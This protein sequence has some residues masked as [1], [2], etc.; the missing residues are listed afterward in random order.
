MAE[1]PNN[2]SKKNQSEDALSSHNPPDLSHGW[3]GEKCEPTKKYRVP[4]PPKQAA[5]I[6]KQQ[7][8]ESSPD[9]LNQTEINEEQPKEWLGVIKSSVSNL[10]QTVKTRIRA[11]KENRLTPEQFTQSL[12]C[13][14]RFAIGSAFFI[15]VAISA[16]AGFAFI[17]Y[18]GIKNSEDFPDV[19][20]LYEKAAQFETTYILDK[21]GNILYEIVD[22]FA[23]RR[24]YVPLEHM[25]PELIAATIATEDQEF[26]NHPGFDPFAIARALIQ[27]YVAHET[28]SG[29]STITQQLSR[30]ILL[31]P[32]ERYEISYT[33]KAKEIVVAAELTRT[34]SKEEIL[35]IYLNQINFGNQSYGIEA[36]ARTYFDTTAANLSLGQ[37]T[38]LAG[39]PQAPALWDV[40]QNPVGALNRQ[41]QVITLTQEMSTENQCI[42]VSSKHD[43]VCVNPTDA[44]AA[45]VEINNYHFVSSGYK[46]TYPHWVNFIRGWLFDRYEESTIYR[47]GFT[48]YTTL[49]PV[50]QERA[51]SI[52]AKQLQKLEGNNASNAALIAIE[53]TTGQVR[54]MVGSADFYNEA[55]SGQVNMSLAPRQPGSSIKPLVYLA[56]FE[57]G[58]TPSTLLWDI[59]LEFPPSG[60]PDD[61]A[62]PYKPTNYDKRYH[63][64]ITVRSALGNSFN[65]P[66]VSTLNYVGIYDNSNTI[67]E[68]GFLKLA[69]RMGITSFVRDDYGLALAL[70]GGEVSL[71]EMTTAFAILGNNGFNVTPSPI[72][73]II[74]HTGQ[75]VYE[76]PG[77]DFK[78]IAR[79]EH[80][81]LISDI[82]SDNNARTP[83][84]GSNSVLNL[85]F[86]AAAKTGTTNDYR[87]NWTI[88]YTPDLAVGVWVGNADYTPMVD[89]TGLS[90]AAPIWSEF[91]QFAVPEI[92]NNAPTS[93]MPPPGIVEELICSLSG[94]EPSS[95]CPSQIKEYFAYDQLPLSK[96]NDFWAEVMVDP[97][98]GF[99]A[100]NECSTKA[101]E[102]FV[103]NIKDADALSW[104]RGTDQGKQWLKSIG[105]EEPYYFL[106]EKTCSTDDPQVTL[107]IAYPRDGETI[108]QSDL[109]IYAIINATNNFDRYVLSYGLGENPDKMEELISETKTY[110]QTS[111]VYRWN[112][113][114]IP[115]GIVTLKLTLYSNNGSKVQETIHINNQAPTSTPT[116]TQTMTPTQ[117]ATQTLEPTM[118]NTP[119]PTETPTQ[120]QIP[121]Q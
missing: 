2:G 106:P 15:I 110:P 57:K 32:E 20:S 58:W 73:K 12:G 42:Y 71:L 29:A 45:L 115:T 18:Q 27:N 87:D 119:S 13:L 81:F 95:W 79:P 35:E 103:I 114:E 11:F 82:L 63:G 8:P 5:R 31:E 76:A 23:G 9:Q 41:I 33:R 21:N 55:I 10:W 4:P 70:G 37:A 90:G 61:P 7:V 120:T 109:E 118:T 48:I 97:W 102:L 72:I 98:T 60:I 53:P 25:S 59:P 1:E 104:I 96:D 26:Y 49:D 74:D 24:T 89:T 34:Y 113:E 91:M 6:P 100:S 44:A 75:L 14:L 84:F 112:L 46:I 30:I 39:L 65:V 86:Q 66:A 16:A 77:P 93:F 99:L 47:S 108:T 17:Q 111:M 43:R 67:E 64:P 83:M 117:T 40:Y 56:A 68:D 38:F 80:A 54:A 52:V 116:L 121:T 19:H 28:V 85:P 69:E 51:E 50:L 36:A 94:T 22:P 62:P 3:Y 105:F 107:E 101:E 78:Q 92:T 88:G